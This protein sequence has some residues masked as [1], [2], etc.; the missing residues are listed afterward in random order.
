M[1]VTSDLLPKRLAQYTAHTARSMKH[2]T[3]LFVL[4]MMG[5]C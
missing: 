5:V 3:T 2:E 1:G 4:V